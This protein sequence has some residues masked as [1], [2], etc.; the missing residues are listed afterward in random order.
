MKG[1][2]VII[3]PEH[4]AG[5]DPLWV[6]ERALAG[7]CALLQLRAKQL[8]DARRLALAHA[9]AERCRAAQVPFWIND[10]ADLALLAGAQ[11]LHL[12][13]HD[14]PVA[15]AKRLVGALPIGL[16]THDLSQVEAANR[17]QVALIGFGPVFETQSKLRPDPLVGL[18]GLA[19]ACA[20]STCPVVAIGGIRLENVAQVARTGARYVAVI[21][22]VCG[23]PDP[24]A[25]AG[26]LNEALARA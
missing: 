20:L 10:R 4:C 2:Y 1:L 14:L 26:A 5:R 25:A 8:S 11:G 7:G 9:L 6:A 13:Q 23:A 16:S 17:E 24:Q 21:G 3:D 19:R 15:E 22:A 12:G 18:E